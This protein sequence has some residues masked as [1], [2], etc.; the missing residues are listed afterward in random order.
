M[1]KNKVLATTRGLLA[2]SSL[3]S[4]YQAINATPFAGACFRIAIYNTTNAAVDI[5]FDGVTDNDVVPATSY[6]VIDAQT[7]AQPNGNEALFQKSLVVYAKGSSASGN[8][9]VSG[10]YVMP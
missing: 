3:S 2:G 8:V 7:N 4:S 10:Y 6:I 1:A 5:S 9:Y